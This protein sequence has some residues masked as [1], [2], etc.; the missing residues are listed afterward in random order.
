[1][2][3]VLEELIREIEAFR[4]DVRHMPV[5]PPAVFHELSEELAAQFD[6]SRPYPLLLLLRKVAALMRRWNLHNTHPRYFGLFSPATKPASVIADALV[7]LYNPQLAGWYASPIANEIEQFT[8]RALA[9]RLGLEECPLAA[10]F[11]TGGAEANMT[12]VLAALNQAFPGYAEAGLRAMEDQP[13]FYISEEAHGSFVKVACATGLGHAAVRRVPGDSTN[14]MDVAALASAVEADLSDG[15]APFMVVGTAGTTASGAID[16]LASLASF[17]QEQRLWLHVDA[18][19]GGAA[20]L[21][22]RL[23]GHL[24][25]IEAADSIS[26]DA[27]K[28]LSVAMGAGMFFCRHPRAV[29]DA[30]H[31]DAS[32]M[33]SRCVDGRDPYVST[34]Q[35]SR[36][37]IGLKVF[38]TVAEMGLDGLGQEIDRMASLGDVLRNKLVMDGWEI[39]NDTP[40]PVVCFTHRLIGNGKIPPADVL[41]CLLSGGSA[42][43]SSVELRGVGTALRACITNYQSGL[44]DVSFLVRTLSKILSDLSDGTSSLGSSGPLSPIP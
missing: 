11:T 22:P 18:A 36:R 28:W 16:P 44:E 9:G 35:W 10:H 41:K 37:F 25:G 4:A 24:V 43:L 17:C 33:P 32:Y 5:V 20:V 2:D 1:M 34:M 7:A 39:L 8:L 12:A 13:V 30:F 3:P 40:L 15:F 6:L 29:R 42:W 38:L 19:W 23:R 14:R 26:W 27:A 21:S 31:V